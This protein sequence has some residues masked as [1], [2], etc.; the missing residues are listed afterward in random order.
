M[1]GNGSS[2]PRKL[3][4]WAR[5]GVAIV[6]LLGLAVAWLDMQLP[7]D[8]SIYYRGHIV[9]TLYSDYAIVLASVYLLLVAAVGRWLFLSRSR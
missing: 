5:C 1:S 4:A 8:D 2:E 6:S 7:R 9:D 3:S